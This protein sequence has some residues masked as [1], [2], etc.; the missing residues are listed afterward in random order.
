LNQPCKRGG[1]KTSKILGA[2][3]LCKLT[4]KNF[5]IAKYVM[6]ELAFKKVLFSYRETFKIITAIKGCKLGLEF[7]NL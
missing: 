5:T 1:H 4:L 2:L 3:E 7:L 6:E